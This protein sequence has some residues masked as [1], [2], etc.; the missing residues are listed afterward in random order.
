[1][2]PTNIANYFPLFADYDGS[3]YFLNETTGDTQWH[4][5]EVAPTTG[6]LVGNLR[7]TVSKTRP[8]PSKPSTATIALPATIATTKKMIIKTKPALPKVEQRKSLPA[9]HSSVPK[10]VHPV[11]SSP[12]ST[13][14]SSLPTLSSSFSKNYHRGPPLQ[15][16][17]T[18]PALT[19]K[20]LA[21]QRKFARAAA[22]QAR[23][24]RQA[25][26]MTDDQ[27]IAMMMSSRFSFAGGDCGAG[28]AC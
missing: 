12:Q 21:L 13:P 16:R 24:A 22:V 15:A 8:S 17:E 14:S 2:S 28:C 27:V 26:G 23:P 1:M 18:K 4:V 9:K 3:V 6:G 11:P 25:S 7:Q 20:A 10:L 5:P 19:A